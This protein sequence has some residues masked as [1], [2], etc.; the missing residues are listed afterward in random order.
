[1]HWLLKY[2]GGCCIYGLNDPPS[3]KEV[4]DIINGLK[5]RKSRGNDNLVN[6][7]LYFKNMCDDLTQLLTRI[8]NV[9]FDTGIFPPTWYKAVIVPVFKKGF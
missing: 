7:Y 5:S 6:E 1:M 3:V 4:V 8:L 9:I 2:R